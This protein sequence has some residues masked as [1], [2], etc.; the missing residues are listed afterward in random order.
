MKL[1]YK[2]TSAKK[3]QFIESKT[4]IEAAILP[5][6]SQSTTFRL[7]KVFV[8]TIFYMFHQPFLHLL[9]RKYCSA[10]SPPVTFF[11]NLVPPYNVMVV[12]KLFKL[13]PNSGQNQVKHTFSL[14]LHNNNKL[15]V[16]N[17][18]DFFNRKIQQ[19]LGHICVFQVLFKFLRSCLWD[20]SRN[21]RDFLRTVRN[22]VT[23]WWNK[24]YMVAKLQINLV[25]SKHFWAQLILD[26]V[27]EK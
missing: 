8:E 16:V 14:K 13:L 11:S 24:L 15:S 18:M 5:I 21:I 19:N 9:G 17:L 22:I 20:F 27:P 1:Y 23:F 26:L 10:L 2:Q 6:R 25:W 12:Q 3:L 4:E 7:M